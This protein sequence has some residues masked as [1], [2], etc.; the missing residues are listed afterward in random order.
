MKRSLT[1]PYFGEGP[2][3]F[4]ED[5]SDPLNFVVGSMLLI[6]YPV[7]LTDSNR[8][9]TIPPTAVRRVTLGWRIGTTVDLGILIAI[10]VVTPWLW[11]HLGTG[12][13]L[14]YAATVFIGGV[15]TLIPSRLAELRNKNPRRVRG[16]GYPKTLRKVI[17]VLDYVIIVAAIVAIVVWG[18][19]GPANHRYLRAIVWGLLAVSVTD[20][21]AFFAARNIAFAYVVAAELAN[22]AQPGEQE[23]GAAAA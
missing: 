21:L 19:G 1:G 2:A 11:P 5:L 18:F 16:T 7:K 20:L 4:W 8:A 3:G 23:E 9:T 17:L 14:V 10:P 13:A 15:V 6:F 12:D 22:E